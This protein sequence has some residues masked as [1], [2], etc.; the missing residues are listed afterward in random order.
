[1]KILTPNRYRAQFIQSDVVHLPT[2]NQRSGVLRKH[3]C[4]NFT[5]RVERKT[6]GF[7][8]ELFGAI[9]MDNIS[10]PQAPIKQFLR[11]IGWFRDLDNFDGKELEGLEV[12]VDTGIIYDNKLGLRPYV[13]RFYPLQ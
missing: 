6:N 7:K 1:M 2:F 11:Q 5:L 10:G 13:I 8:T 3:R 9:P 4:L 12:T